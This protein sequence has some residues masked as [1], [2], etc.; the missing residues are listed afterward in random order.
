MN[1]TEFSPGDVAGFD[2]AAWKLPDGTYKLGSG[3]I[4]TEFPKEITCNNIVYTFEEIVD[5]GNDFVN[6][7]YV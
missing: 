6:V 4:V 7:V 1:I 5:C 3:K 2:L